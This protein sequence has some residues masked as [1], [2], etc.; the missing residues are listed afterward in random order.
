MLWG[1]IM[2]ARKN[3]TLTE[4]CE[5]LLK[6][7]DLLPPPQLNHRLI[8]FDLKDLDQKSRAELIWVLKEIGVLQ[9]DENTNQDINYL[10]DL[11]LK[12][13]ENQEQLLIKKQYELV[14]YVAENREFDAF[15]EFIKRTGQQKSTEP[16][17]EELSSHEKRALDEDLTKQTSQLKLTQP[18]TELLLSPFIKF[19]YDRWV[20]PEESSDKKL[21]LNLIGHD[22]DYT[23][24]PH[25]RITRA[26]YLLAQRV[27][28]E[29]N[30]G[31]LESAKIHPYTYLFPLFDADAR[32]F[33]GGLCLKNFKLHEILFREDGGPF[34]V[35]YMLDD[36]DEYTGRQTERKPTDS[37]I[38]SFA[39]KEKL[40]FVRQRLARHSKHVI[41]Y[42]DAIGAK[43]SATGDDKIKATQAVIM[44]REALVE[45]FKKDDYQV[46]ASYGPSGVKELTRYI[47]RGF[48]TSREFV[49][50]LADVRHLSLCDLKLFFS[51]MNTADLCRMILGLNIQQD[52][53]NDD[54]YEKALLIQAKQKMLELVKSDLGALK[55]NT[56]Q[57]CAYGMGLMSI[58]SRDRFNPESSDYNSST[59]KLSSY[60]V[61]IPT[62]KDKEV[63][64]NVF[65]DFLV[66]VGEEQINERTKCPYKLTMNDLN[67][68][69]EKEKNH[70]D[71]KLECAKGSYS[72]GLL[73][74]K[75][76]TPAQ[77]L[78]EYLTVQS[79]YYTSHLT[80]MVQA[81]TKA[82]E[83]AKILDKNVQHNLQK[84]CG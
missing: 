84:A 7:L 60:V 31:R 48:K 15:R 66:A 38:A 26:C 17:K 35:L 76:K 29:L 3:K 83:P 62:K 2:D 5:S 28:D 53:I 23:I 68:Y 10:K 80:T 72:A 81:L 41:A 57:L 25:S 4:F 8:N 13:Q 27:C 55:F 49:I 58:Y 37:V 11:L 9:A 24:R 21:K 18:A 33:K 46:T 40:P 65:W 30:I 59:S 77:V 61:S 54:A 71:S 19:L 63:L 16:T 47:L 1:G 39:R 12:N 74:T 50:A 36:M 34:S 69:L 14:L 32:V 51:T 79:T 67:V 64:F 70:I 78:F 20:S 45:A 42:F 56:K 6:E 75:A 43:N 52:G 22:L 44:A 73:W 82:G